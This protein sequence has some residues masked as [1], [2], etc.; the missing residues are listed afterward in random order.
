MYS[1]LQFVRYLLHAQTLKDM[2]HLAYISIYG[3]GAAVIWILSS[4]VNWDNWT[5]NHT[6][7]ACKAACMVSDVKRYRFIPFLLLQVQVVSFLH[8]YS[9]AEIVF[10]FFFYIHKRSSGLHTLALT[11]AFWMPFYFSLWRER[12]VKRHRRSDAFHKLSRLKV[13]I[14]CKFCCYGVSKSKTKVICDV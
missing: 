6:S 4:V 8:S 12:R 14:V 9:H 3:E 10:F 2:H 5:L 13:Y 7:E 1:T 11:S